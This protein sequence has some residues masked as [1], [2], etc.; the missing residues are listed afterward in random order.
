MIGS[1]IDNILIDL[2]VNHT[3]A[4]FAALGNKYGDDFVIEKTFPGGHTA[5]VDVIIDARRRFDFV[6]GFY[7][8]FAPNYDTY[9]TGPDAQVITRVWK[10]VVAKNDFGGSVLDLGCG[11]G[12]VGNLIKAKYSSE[13]VGVDLCPEMAERAKATAYSKV[14]LGRMENV[15]VSEQ[16]GKQTFDHV[17]SVGVLMYLDPKNFQ[18]VLGRAFDLAQSSVT[19]TVENIEEPYRTQFMALHPCNVIWN[20]Y[21]VVKAFVPPR[22]WSLVWQREDELW[23]SPTTRDVV[24]GVTVRFEKD[25]A[26]NAKEA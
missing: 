25:Q 21:E 12:L 22:G 14:I 23:T 18:M 3:P 13:L 4:F 26:R 6:R 15:V 16:L 9:V 11:T 1:I 5:L 19:L 24:S 20:H 2:Q 10:E 17:L 8:E 7:G